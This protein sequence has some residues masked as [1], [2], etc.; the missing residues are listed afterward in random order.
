MEILAIIP[1]R[2]GS[3]GI[4]M[5]NIVKLNGKPL[6]QYS[7]ISSLKSKLISRTVVSTD[8]QK[9]E[10]MSKNFG[11][12]VIKRP[13]ILA[14]NKI[15]MEPAIFHVL[16]KLKKNEGYIPE[17]I[18]ILPVTSPLRTNKKGLMYT[19]IIPPSFRLAQKTV[20]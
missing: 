6:L 14:N 10:R 13:K 16:K 3:K 5:K 20:L 15:Q 11:A 12:E 7:I 1:A 2:G 17:I 19:K 8:N 9:I 4:P 18:I